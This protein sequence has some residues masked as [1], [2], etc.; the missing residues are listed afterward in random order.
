MCV[1]LDERGQIQM[2]QVLSTILRKLFYLI[3]SGKQLKVSVY[4]GKVSLSVKACSQACVSGYRMISRKF[5]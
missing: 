2:I 4:F 1:V 5:I 3:R